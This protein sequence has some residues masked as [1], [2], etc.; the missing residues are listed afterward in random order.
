MVF[1]ARDCGRAPYVSFCIDGA[2][3][4][5]IPKP[6]PLPKQNFRRIFSEVGAGTKSSIGEA[7]LCRQGA[8][9][10]LASESGGLLEK[11]GKTSQCA[12]I[13]NRLPGFRQDHP[14]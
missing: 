4:C 11:F 1:G 13:L 6:T 9:F 3:L 5:G 10:K 8:R 14:R 2:L 12:V 7:N